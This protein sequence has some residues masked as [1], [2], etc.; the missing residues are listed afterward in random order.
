MQSQDSQ[1]ML[2]FCDMLF[3]CILISFQDAT[4][5][6]KDIQLHSVINL[7]TF[8]DIV[9]QY[10]IDRPSPVQL[11]KDLI[12]WDSF[13]KKLKGN[14]AVL[15]DKTALHALLRVIIVLFQNS[16]NNPVCWIQLFFMQCNK[17]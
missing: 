6:T 8:V 13:C 14:T 15:R 17:Y 5:S 10:L 3:R 11:T 4:S 7:A 12:L 2:K 1:S 9:E 16:L